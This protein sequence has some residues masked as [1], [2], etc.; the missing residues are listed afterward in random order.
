MTTDLRLQLSDIHGDKIVLASVELDLELF[1]H[2]T[3]K[4]QRLLLGE[5]LY[6]QHILHHICVGEGSKA[7][8]RV[9]AS[10]AILELQSRVLS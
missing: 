10:L 8:S 5:V 3:M 6:I 2:T 4:T 9:S 1:H 7:V